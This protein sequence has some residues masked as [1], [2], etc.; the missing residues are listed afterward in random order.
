MYGLPPDQ[1]KEISFRKRAIAQLS[2]CL[3]GPARL[4]FC[5]L[6][7]G[8]VSVTAAGAAVEELEKRGEE[9]LYRVPHGW[10]WSR[11]GQLDEHAR[12]VNEISTGVNR[13]PAWWFVRRQAFFPKVV[14][15]P[16]TV[17]SMSGD[18]AE[19]LYHWTFDVLPRLRML[20]PARRAQVRVLARLKYPFNRA[21]LEA[22]GF[23]P[24]S[25]IPAEPMT[26]YRTD[27]LLAASVVRGI[28]P[29]NFACAREIYLK[30]AGP[31]PAPSTPVRLYISRAKATS[32]K[33]VNEAELE[34]ELRQRGFRIAFFE[35]L[36]F[37]EQLALISQA[38]IIVSAHGAAWTLVVVAR[39]GTPAIEILP[40]GLEAED[41]GSYH[42][43]R[44]LCHEAGLDYRAHH[45]EAVLHKSETQK[46]H[47]NDIR[48]SIAKFLDEIDGCLKR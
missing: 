9:G 4:K 21:S 35:E 40:A 29:A 14:D 19:N 42:L 37:A 12:I 25:I 32:R 1:W 5:G 13:P 6:P 47:Q 8:L 23:P 26:L 43:F 34:E 11:G 31:V 17:F 39:P 38:E 41:P 33:I 30:A 44:N 18:T 2:R 45:G 48:V 24:D 10:V 16:G 28:T 3:P 22:A 46:A 27:E 20:D 36:P 7:S 15:C